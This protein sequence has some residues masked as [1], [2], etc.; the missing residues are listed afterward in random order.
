MGNVFSRPWYSKGTSPN[1]VVPLS[2]PVAEPPT[3]ALIKD[4][5][6]QSSSRAVSLIA[7]AGFC[8]RWQATSL[9]LI[10]TAQLEKLLSPAS[11]VKALF[12]EF[13]TARKYI[14][15]SYRWTPATALSV[16]IISG[17]ETWES[18]SVTTEV[19]QAVL[20]LAKRENIEWI[21]LD[22][23]CINQSN[24]E[25]GARDKA[26]FIP[27]MSTVFRYAAFVAA[28]G[29][30]T[31]DL[32]LTEK[33]FDGDQIIWYQR[34]WTLQEMI[35]A[36]KLM[37]YRG[38]W[39][40]LD[41][42]RNYWAS[43]Y[44]KCLKESV[45]SEVKYAILR[46][47][48]ELGAASKNDSL[49]LAQILYLISKRKSQ[50]DQD[51]VFGILG[52]L[53]FHSAL[54]VNYTLSIERLW[55]HLCQE[56]IANG[57]FSIMLAK[58]TATLA[59]DGFID[60]GEFKEHKPKANDMVLGIDQYPELAL[61][62]ANVEWQDETVTYDRH[63]LSFLKGTE[64]TIAAHSQ[65]TGASPRREATAEAIQ[66]LEERAESAEWKDP[67]DSDK[68]TW[69]CQSLLAVRTAPST[70][71][72][73]GHEFALKSTA[74]EEEFTVTV[75]TTFV[76]TL[77]ES[78]DKL[79][80]HQQ[81]TVSY[82]GSGLLKMSS[83]QDSEAPTPRDVG[84]IAGPSATPAVETDTVNNNSDENE[85]V[86]IPPPGLQNL[87]PSH[88]FSSSPPPPLSPQP[89]VASTN[90]TS[91]A[92][93]PQPPSVASISIGAR[94][95]RRASIRPVSFP[96]SSAPVPTL[97]AP[98]ANPQKITPKNIKELVEKSIRLI[99]PNAKSKVVA[100]GTPLFGFGHNTKTKLSDVVQELIERKMASK[101]KASRWWSMLRV[102]VKRGFFQSLMG[103]TPTPTSDFLS[104]VETLWKSVHKHITPN[105]QKKQSLKDTTTEIVMSGWAKIKEAQ[106]AAAR[107]RAKRSTESLNNTRPPT[108][109]QQKEGSPST[110]GQQK[111]PGE[112]EEGTGT[113]GADYERSATSVRGTLG[114][115]G[116]SLDNVPSVHISRALSK[117][118]DGL[119]NPLVE[120][121][122]YTAQV[123]FN[124]A[125]KLLLLGLMQAE[126]F[127][128]YMAM[129]ALKRAIPVIND[130]LLDYT[131]RENL[132]RVLINLMHSDERKE[133][134]LKAVYL[135]GQLAFH[136]G[137]VREHDLLLLNAF[138][139]LA[140]RF[141]EIQYREKIKDPSAPDRF[142]SDNRSMKIH[143]VQSIG[144]FTKHS[145]K[146]ARYIEDLVVY[147]LHEEF[148]SGDS[149][150]SKNLFGDLKVVLESQTGPGNDGS[151]FVLKSL[152]GVLDYEMKH[153]ESNEK[154]IGA[155]FKSFIHPLMKATNKGL[156]M[157]AV[158]FISSWLPVRNEDALTIG[159][160][161]VEAGLKAARELGI[162][163]LT[164]EQYE[165]ELKGL[166]ARKANEESRMAVRA[167]LLRQVLQMPGTFAKLKPATD[168][169][170][171]FIEIDSPMLG[172]AGIVVS[173]PV[174]PKSSVT[175]TRPLP[176]IPGVPA[177][178][179]TIPPVFMEPAWI[180]QL[181]PPKFRYEYFE[182][183]RG[184]PG[185]PFGYTYA[186]APLVDVYLLKNIPRPQRKE[187]MDAEAEKGNVGAIV[188]AQATKKMS[189]ARGSIFKKNAKYDSVVMSNASIGSSLDQLAELP[190]NQVMP[191]SGRSLSMNPAQARLMIAAAGELRRTSQGGQAPV[192]PKRE[193]G[194]GF[195]KR[196]SVAGSSIAV[197]NRKA[198]VAG[199][200]AARGS[201]FDKRGSIFMP[202]EELAKQPIPTG[203][204]RQPAKEEFLAQL[205]VT[206]RDTHSSQSARVPPGFL[207]M[208]PFPGFDPDKVD[209][210]VQTLSAIYTFQE[211]KKAEEQG[212]MDGDAL[213]TAPAGYT[214]ERNPVL[215]PNKNPNLKEVTE[216]S[217]FPI[218]APVL[219][220]II[221]PG[222]SNL[223]RI[224]CQVT[225]INKDVSAVTVQKNISQGNLLTVGATF[226]LFIRSR[227]NPK[228]W[229]CVNLEVVDDDYQDN[230]VFG[231]L[232][233]KGSNSGSSLVGGT[234][235]LTGANMGSNAALSKTPSAIDNGRPESL[236]AAS[237]SSPNPPAV[238]SSLPAHFP[239]PSGFT[240]SGDPYFSPPVNIPPIPVGYTEEMAP[241]YG[242]T[243][244]IKF[245]PY[246]VTT[247][248]I[249]FYSPEGKL[250]DGSRLQVGGYDNNGHPF[251][252]PKGCSVP[253]PVG[254]TSD[255]IPYYDIPALMNH[256]GIMILP[257]FKSLNR[258]PL[259][260]DIDDGDGQLQFAEGSE[261]DLRGSGSDLA[262]VGRKRF[263]PIAA[264]NELLETLKAT[265][266]E[267]T[268][269]FGKSRNRLGTVKR[270]EDINA[271]K[272]YRIYEDDIGEDEFVNEPDDIVAYLKESEDF[273]YLK[274]P[275]MKVSLEPTN[276]EFQSVITPVN[277]SVVLRY[278]AG[279]GDHEERDLFI[280]V[281][282]VEVFS[283]GNFHLRVQGEGVSQIQL[284][285]N[286][287]AMNTERV[288]GSLSLLDESGKKLASCALVAL[289]QSFVKATPTFLDAGWVLPEK[290]KDI[291]LRLDNVSNTVVTLG[292]DLESE[293]ET[294]QVAQAAAVV[295][296]QQEGVD[297]DVADINEE[298]KSSPFI[299]SMKTLKLQ[300][301][302]SKHVPISF[303]P[304][305]LGR[306]LDTLEIT[307]PGGEKLKIKLSGVGGI[308]IAIYPES[309][310]N[311]IAGGEALTRERCEFMKKFTRADSTSDKGRIP[312]TDD[313]I[314]ILQNMMSA[315]ADND[316]RRDA[317]TL[318][319]GI[320]A[321]NA[322]KLTRCVTIMNL[323]DSPLSLGLYPHHQALSSKY[324]IKVPARM[325]Q[326]VEVVLDV[327]S[328]LYREMKGNVRTAIEVVC[329]EFQ[330][331]P[332]TVLAFVGQPLVFN[333]WD[334]AFFKPCKIGYTEELLMTLT[335][336]SHYE[337]L[338]RLDGLSNSGRPSDTSN[339][340]K[341]NVAVLE[342]DETT[343][344]PFAMMPVSFAFN[345]RQRGPLM[346][347]VGI[348][349]LSPGEWM[350][351]STSTGRK[352]TLVGICIEPY[353]RK[354]EDVDKNGL[355]FLRMWV[356]HPKRLL[357]EYPSEATERERLFDTYL[358]AG[359]AKNDMFAEPSVQFSNDLLK[360]RQARITS[361]G[362]D[363]SPYK[364]AQIQHTQVHNTT[365][366]ELKT[367]YFASMMF[368]VEPRYRPLRKGET[369]NCDIMFNPTS[370]STENVTSFGFAV[371]LSESDHN[372]HAMQLIGKPAS[373]FLVCP[374]AVR[375]EVFL[376]FGIMEVSSH[377]LEINTK[378]VMLCNTFDTSYSWSL[379]F[380]LTGKNK[381][382]PFEAAMSFGELQ[383]YET[384]ALPFRFHCDT[385]GTFEVTAEINAKDATERMAKATK[386]VTVVLRGQTVNTSIGGFPDNLDFGSS[387]VLKPKAKTFTVVNNGT[388]STKVTLLA[389]PP[390]T[391][392]PQTFEI[393]I[394]GSQDV[395]V[396]F[397]PTESRTSQSKMYCFSNQKLHIMNLVGSGGT[398]D[399][400]C[401]KFESKDIDFGKQR[402][403]T[404]AWMSLYL[405]N[406]G[407]LPL[408]LTGIT[409][410]LPDL[411]KVEFLSVTSTLPYEESQ[412][413][414][415]S[416]T[417]S[418]RPDF[419]SI[420][421]RKYKVFV[422]LRSLVR[423]Q[424]RKK[425]PT[426]KVERRSVADTTEG[427]T[428]L[429]VLQT[430]STVVSALFAP[431][432]PQLRPF[433]S[434]H[435][436]IGYLNKYQ[437][438]KD[439]NV[440]FHYMPITNEEGPVDFTAL[441]KK[442]TVH[443]VGQVYRSLEF[444]PNFHDFGLAPAES[445]SAANTTRKRAN[446]I[447][448]YGVQ[449][450]GHEV[451]KGVFNFQVINMSLE[452]QNLFLKSINPEFTINGRTWSVS[453]GQK[454]SIPIEFHPSKEQ[455]QYRG[456]AVFTH[457]YGN[458]TVEFIGT[459]ASAD[460]SADDVIDFG[461]LKLDSIG[462]YLF[463]LCN[464]GLLE[465]KFVLELVQ[466]GTDFRFAY[467][468]PFERD[469]TIT[470]GA[471]EIIEL[472]CCCHKPLLTKPYLRMLWE[473]IPG[474]VWEEVHV[475]ITVAIGV[476]LFKLSTLEVDFKTTYINVNKTLHLIATNEGNAACAWSAEIQ[477]DLVIM[478]PDSGQI[479]AG[480]SV[481]I[482]LTYI[483]EDYNPLI[484]EITFETDA[485]QK[486]VMCYGIVGVPYLVISEA[487]LNLDFGIAAIERT[488]TKNIQLKNTGNKPIEFEITM[489]ELTQDGAS[490]AKEAFEVFF[491]NPTD[492]V[493]QPGQT[494]DVAIQAMTRQ[495][496]TTISAQYIVRT[497]DG[498][499]YIGR[500][501]ITGGKAII[502]IAPP[503]ITKQ[504]GVEAHAAEM[505]QMTP[506]SR[507]REAAAATPTTPGGAQPS[508]META[509]LAF[510]SHLENL[511]DVLAG[512]RTAEMEY[513]EDMK[514]K[515]DSAETSL[516]SLPPLP[517]SSRRESRL[518]RGKMTEDELN[519]KKLEEER[520]KSS[521]GHLVYDG[522]D[523]RIRVKKAV[524]DASSAVSRAQT[525]SKSN[526]TSRSN[527]MSPY[528]PLGPITPKTEKASSAP[529]EGQGEMETRPATSALEGRRTRSG[530]IRLTAADGA[531]EL[532]STDSVENRRA[533]RSVASAQRRKSALAPNHEK[534]EESTAVQFLDE[535]ATLEAELETISKV[536][537]N[538]VQGMHPQSGIGR[539]NPGTPR[540]LTH[541]RG[542][543]APSTRGKSRGGLKMLTEGESEEDMLSMSKSST[544]NKDGRKKSVARRPL[545]DL[546]ALAQQ[547]LLNVHSVVDSDV[548]KELVDE[549][550]ERLI[551]STKGIIAAVKDQLA[552][553]WIVNR[554]F[555]TDALKRVQ[556]TTHI[557]EAI[558]VDSPEVEKLE[559]DF[560][561]GLIR[562]GDRASDVL[563][564]SLPNT[565]NLEFEFEMVS[566]ENV[567]IR[568]PGSDKEAENFDMFQVS[569]RKGTVRPGESV[570]FCVNF[571]AVTPGLYQQG[572]ELRSDG[573]P[574]TNFTISARVGLPIIRVEPSQL[575][576]GLIRRGKS[577][578]RT[579][580]ITNV[581]TYKDFWRIEITRGKGAISLL[582]TDSVEP[583]PGA[584]SADN[585]Q[586]P[587]SFN[588]ISGSLEPG[589]AITVQLKFRPPE[590]GPFQQRF[591]L[592]WG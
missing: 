163:T 69:I 139:A 167:K 449:K 572:Y 474:G 435:F 334:Y 130:T 216:C 442:M 348:K 470:S 118:A 18:K 532:G 178:V 287:A 478:D 158:H 376:D 221:Q 561:L 257:S 323:S 148:A 463:R 68:L 255:G 407:T 377:T 518:V 173:L 308:P 156:Q 383:P 315:T 204:L 273:A 232:R 590:E 80:I 582:G 371:A 549:I 113:V 15:V 456:E 332:L 47:L 484:S 131:T 503:K 99:S 238:Q 403:G 14:A 181:Q 33:G 592:L 141:L 347:T 387:I 197:K 1:R 436:R 212:L 365:S 567:K 122:F 310:E 246:G 194:F 135:I 49:S 401:E 169:P 541:S 151:V 96:S 250:S 343:I 175:L 302:E 506:S 171:F 589:D 11:R 266:L 104:L 138:K 215:W 585:D 146:A 394:K 161:T 214:I 360:F 499:R 486:S 244:S 491:A 351:P 352:L 556:Q 425:S 331:I 165:K 509:R 523:L 588:H 84:D 379:K 555:L 48:A 174:H 110:P 412:G 354:P 355:E 155:L 458:H 349:V 254:F 65:S 91:N 225:S 580:I 176:P 35:L 446:S 36:K 52:L 335:N 153:T 563:L 437:A 300:P 249:R 61:D 381:Y 58:R 440:H 459:G 564:F 501:S 182:R 93:Q 119:H 224:L 185:L 228:E 20:E 535:L 520:R 350:M 55:Y 234:S 21:W 143:L 370:D 340:F 562:S 184:I 517:G 522:S 206:K 339:H 132:V 399:L 230:F 557:M 63:K 50:I 86:Y 283:V 540:R 128:R 196:Q 188:K 424:H 245:E 547:M 112:K 271:D 277:K 408:M 417:L 498:E 534:I 391:V 124:R 145:L 76:P 382:N 199:G 472:Q 256:R 388:T 516:T 363:D 570:Q 421:R 312:L 536:L 492:G 227:A 105:S 101:S 260:D 295:L 111:T 144:K 103:T 429:T 514:R 235:L 448:L 264:T 392:A 413:S 62:S 220:D 222:S 369:G 127:A 25:V 321:N 54:K 476:P 213:P 327:N 71:R 17:V 336:M 241:Y 481:K 560:D 529:T 386:I 453:P 420:L 423:K 511:Q 368:N 159:F 508:Q 218:N 583:F 281:E 43:A 24:N 37:V 296:Q 258:P 291:I 578:T 286:P 485:G 134:R 19:L 318:D 129:C 317:H 265:Q 180:E 164:K 428:P 550:N 297:I 187:L 380:M 82:P 75:P 497:R 579:L 346:A 551:E 418:I 568:P 482:D 179:T 28:Y 389:K 115:E 57:D 100:P 372:Y 303:E 140:K 525:S 375:D 504:P 328:E 362:E 521:S 359:S 527:V 344:L 573:T 29:A 466:A 70:P 533:A 23:W 548:Q 299:M 395:T 64:C 223:Q 16:N 526:T 358:G 31:S 106:H 438:K 9:R 198:S 77:N 166:R 239:H 475:P 275:S 419:W 108:A 237:P 40:T 374:A 210:N 123:H 480:E 157:M 313:D 357:D 120:A 88:S 451:K 83:G 519:Q 97:T 576:F 574:V 320:C 455:L 32:K 114:L 569:P 288:E 133:N 546:V 207:S 121:D 72:N 538:I 307:A 243:A 240:A 487:D 452:P 502:K 201:I 402:E 195:V 586:N 42:E 530:R 571:Y 447:A 217:D 367:S 393:P 6:S 205:Q 316:S 170:G 7:D 126:P 259:E 160:E 385:S 554:E 46:I 191:F 27:L 531:E 102:Q 290:K 445:W 490:A 4:K 409:A 422:A 94:L 434:Y 252:I 338:F 200:G 543:T 468:E 78:K 461:N 341:S 415:K 66:F 319:F 479:E 330:N 168:N 192:E 272:L 117:I 467:N 431:A 390:F 591:T 79:T 209:K 553:E 149:K 537:G 539:Y 22:S 305:N 30:S 460:I 3:P 462:S 337:I 298:I 162:N 38:G 154:Y 378:M 190:G 443:V 552:N 333:S 469:G 203:M 515:M 483:P 488:H 87:E 581:G 289:K 500:M 92:P 353:S 507:G 51:R 566:T 559:N 13:V 304:M 41:E 280:S 510:Q 236:V 404:I 8:A 269:T 430:G 396:L 496:N 306:F 89:F 267:L 397:N 513:A 494:F 261:S 329:P 457:N 202:E 208:C 26:R 285:Y 293:L 489:T 544:P 150:V 325:A 219:F 524:S 512:L 262:L 107:I 137:N 545:E 565:G 314:A 60:D 270:L 584:A 311:S 406:K 439:T 427:G 342:G 465:G 441:I 444:F 44:I 373:D 59:K 410:D 542:D 364:R 136:L 116:L 2:T 226:N 81:L 577:D 301:G 233:S 10:P 471:S 292:F 186:P 309:V 405:T 172:T 74:N 284:T 495:Y 12:P 454:L 242:K 326:S 231:S 56:A 384:F 411:I 278:R 493:V 109:K 177:A 450:E 426:A 85:D 398:A 274:P 282:P 247:E 189:L 73:F 276:L 414:G 45:S 432:A 98:P 5:P 34:V 193:A 125:W 324:L 95:P 263:D 248:G 147:M 53:P 433:F 366:S 39:L 253:Q 505:K 279:R 322:G 528:S 67:I 416:A 400:V 558:H 464:R 251:Y 477:S 142:T 90:A 575:D 152:L 294:R 211:S 268:Q 229:V 356:S 345:G 587:F 361:L 183:V 473:R